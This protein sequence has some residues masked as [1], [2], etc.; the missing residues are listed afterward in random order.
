MGNV[1]DELQRKKNENDKMAA[2]IISVEGGEV[3]EVF[4][5]TDINNSS[6]SVKEAGIFHPNDKPKHRFLPT[7]NINHFLATSSPGCRYVK[8]GGVWKK[9]CR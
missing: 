4:E 2:V 6:I 1:T 8:V 5:V 3:L 7:E 9:V